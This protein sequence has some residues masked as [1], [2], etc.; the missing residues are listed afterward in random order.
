MWVGFILLIIVL[1]AI[2]L[3]V[4]NRKSHQI[5]IKEALIWAG[6][7]FGLAMVFNIWIYFQFGN[8][9]ALQFFTGYLIEKSL[10]VDNLFVFLVIFTAFSVP[11][12]Y[13]HRVLFWGILGAIITR[14]LFIGLGTTIIEHFIWAFFIFGLVLLYAAYKMQFGAEKRFDPDQSRIV[15]MV[16]KVV[17][18]S[19]KLD[20]NRFFTREDGKRAITL[21]FLT[22]IVIELTDIIFAFDSIPAIFAIT[23]DP[24]LVFTS[25]I[26][27]IMG[28]RSLY[29]VLADMQGMF[30][31]LKSGLAV[32]LLFI[33][34]K[35]LLKPFHIEVPIAISLAFI[36]CVLAIAII[37]SV[38]HHRRHH[39]RAGPQAATASAPVGPSAAQQVLPPVA[40]PE[41]GIVY[42]APS[43]DSSAVPLAAPAIIPEAARTGPEF[44]RTP[45]R[46]A[47]RRRPSSKGGRAGRRPKSTTKKKKL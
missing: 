14:G 13:Q 20:G 6:V 22:L 45:A 31:Y 10:S 29:F 36:L 33:A 35:L 44:E 37:L 46:S 2:D 43:A 12:E 42:A 34:V 4:F 23:T 16:R 3:G 8:E 32:I 28:L 15:R 30:E 5:T 21:L 26:F 19:H 40:I 17:P 38:L 25:N 9:S 39:V 27:A 7:W 47:P 24:F 11:A 1:L 18:V 41:Q